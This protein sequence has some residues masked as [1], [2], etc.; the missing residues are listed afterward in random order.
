[1]GNHSGIA[2]QPTE[3]PLYHG[4]RALQQWLIS[5]VLQATKPS[6]EQPPLHAV[7][8]EFQNIIESDA[9]IFMHA[10]AMFQQVPSE[11]PYDNDPLG[12]PQI[13]DYKQMLQL[14]NSLLT[15]APKWDNLV[16]QIGWTGFPI[17]VV[18][19][20][21]M[22][23]PSGKAFFLHDRVNAQLKKVL[24]T[25]AEHLGS[26][27]SANV[28]TTDANGW[29]GADA[30]AAMERVA[31]VGTTSFT[32]EQLFECNPSLPHWGFTSWDDFFVR[33]FRPG[34]RPVAGPDDDNIIANPC[35]SK[36]YRLATNVAR[37]DTFWVKGQPYS[38][39]DMLAQDELARH[40][41]GGTVYQAFL[42]SLSYHRWHSPV[43]G[44]VV[45][46]RLVPGTYYSKA[47]SQGFGSLHKSL[48]PSQGY[49]TAV[50]TRALIFIEADN[51][52]IGLVC[53]M[54]VGM[55]EV[56]TC[57]TTVIP[58]QRVS[59]GQ[60]LGMFHFGGST[61]CLL[62]RPETVLQWTAQASMV[63][64]PS[65]NIPVNAEIARA[66]IA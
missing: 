37:R 28:L 32:F 58:G 62:F 6:H 18:L 4:S 33:R 44:T 15:A 34:L 54:P 16:F 41:V 56:S 61:T 35:E 43:S 50:A 23:T 52:A 30:L 26:G 57:E 53:V 2:S 48:S 36:P 7:I 9:I 45:K 8:R 24:D 25:W 38:I 39:L 47:E 60:E 27:A 3:A 5:M 46:T 17:N 22:S 59:K 66:Q 49:L 31:N 19:N 12:R 10:C 14:M 55:A 11:S 51:P 63:E 65:F 64:N 29:L 21:P 1:M 13:R 20:W 42:S 40:F